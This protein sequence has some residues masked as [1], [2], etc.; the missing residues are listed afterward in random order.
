MT[1]P[2]EYPP[3]H[4][5]AVGASEILSD[6]PL[7]SGPAGSILTEGEYNAE[8]KGSVRLTIDFEYEEAHLKIY[9]T[10]A[11]ARSLA[12]HLIAATTIAESSLT[13]TPAPEPW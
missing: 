9:L 8:G 2:Q 10:S 4:Y 13:Q 12:T 6:H 3:L 1:T 5:F 11:E 7:G